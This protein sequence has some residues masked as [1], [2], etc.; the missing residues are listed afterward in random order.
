MTYQ[1]QGMCTAENNQPG[2]ETRKSGS[3]PKHLMLC[4]V[5]EGKGE[6]RSWYQLGEWVRFDSMEKNNFLLSWVTQ[7]WNKLL[8]TVKLWIVFARG[9]FE[10]LLAPLL[11]RPVRWLRPGWVEW[12]S[13]SHTGGILYQK[14]WLKSVHHSSLLWNLVSLV[15]LSVV[16][17]DTQS[18]KR[19]DLSLFPFIKVVTRKAWRSRQSRMMLLYHNNRSFLGSSIIKA[20][21]I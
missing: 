4:C 21:S 14:T 9:N 2:E 6:Q 18:F 15:L 12:L 5:E 3:C 7:Q 11:Y 10:I 16:L 17:R 20:Q 1:D 8:C 19:R 13:Q